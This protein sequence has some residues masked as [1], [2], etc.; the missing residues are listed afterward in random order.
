MSNTI[1]TITP[2]KCPHCLEDILIEFVTTSPE[3]TLV[4]TKEDVVNTKNKTIALIEATTLDSAKKQEVI[5]WINEDS[6]IFGESEIDEI[7]S[8]LY[9]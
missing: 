3:V 1:K 8:S 5:N 2:T 4:F 7:I 9:K 6:T